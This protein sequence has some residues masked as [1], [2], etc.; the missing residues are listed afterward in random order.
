MWRVMRELIPVLFKQKK[1]P[2]VHVVRT[3]P[4]E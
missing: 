1:D 4:A 2:A 3:V